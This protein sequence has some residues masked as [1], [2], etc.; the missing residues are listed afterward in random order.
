MSI[1]EI[2]I[3]LLGLAILVTLLIGWW[4]TYVV[5]HS[6]NQAKF[7]QGKADPSTL[8]GDYIGTVPGHT[9]TWQGK[10][11]NRTDSSGVNRFKENNTIVSKYPFKT[12]VGKGLRDKQLDVIKLDYNQPGNPW[13]LKF[14]VDEIV[15]TAPDTY[16]GKVHIQLAPRLTF[17]VGFFTLEKIR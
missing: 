9:F 13:W 12:Y 4:R 8:D 6:P 10:T 11:L 1:I 2:L 15:Q 7:R 3:K 5:A 14:I 17:T 16:L